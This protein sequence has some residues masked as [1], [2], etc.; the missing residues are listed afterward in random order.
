MASEEVDDDGRDT[1][2]LR[3]GETGFLSVEGF[4]EYEGDA[5]ACLEGVFDEQFAQFE[6]VQPA[7]TAGGDPIEGREEGT[8][9]AAYTYTELD[10]EEEIERTAYV[11]CQTLIPGESV[12]LFTLITTSDDFPEDLKATREVIASL[13]LPAAVGDTSA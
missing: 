5:D 13:E 10:R 9:F 8:A 7:T 12:V 11:H 4:A 3:R 6:D 1:L 2:R